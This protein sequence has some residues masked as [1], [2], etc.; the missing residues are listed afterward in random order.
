M[1][2][3][4][5]GTLY[6][7]VTNDLTKRVSEH[8]QK[9]IDGFT[10]KYNCTMLVWYQSDHDIKSLIEYE[11]MIKGWKRVRKLKLIETMNPNWDDLYDSLF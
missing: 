11:K 7:G 9:L 8:K 3:Q 10:K 4:R 6:V 2:N 1:T 5:N